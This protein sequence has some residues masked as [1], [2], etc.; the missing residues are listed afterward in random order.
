MKKFATWRLEIL[1]ELS[2]KN[3]Q[4]T[5]YCD[6]EFISHFYKKCCTGKAT[7]NGARYGCVIGKGTAWYRLHK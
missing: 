4:R 7:Q 6:R 3:D 5:F 2:L 1:V